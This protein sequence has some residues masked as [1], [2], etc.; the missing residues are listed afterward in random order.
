MQNRP[1]CNR[2]LVAASI[3]LE[4]C[5]RKKP[6]RLISP[7]TPAYGSAGP[8]KVDESATALVYACSEPVSLRQSEAQ[9]FKMDV[10]E[11]DIVG[12]HAEGL[13]QA[14]S[15]T[16]PSK[17]WRAKNEKQVACSRAPICTKQRCFMHLGLP[18]TRA[19]PRSMDGAATDRCE[20]TLLDF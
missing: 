10:V 11:L 3:A 4:D 18:R 14:F 20:K 7:A 15:L 12:K 9:R 8:T 17:R 16:K 1:R 13:H 2:K 6:K 19:Y 5:P